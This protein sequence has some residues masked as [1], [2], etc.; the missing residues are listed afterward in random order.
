MRHEKSTGGSESSGGLQG[1]CKT[2][3]RAVQRP[4]E[5]L[6]RASA[7]TSNQQ[8]V[9]KQEVMVEADCELPGLG[10]KD[11]PTSPQALI[12]HWE[13]GSGLLGRPLSVLS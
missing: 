10:L 8:A 12:K 5:G 11:S 7:V 1:V 2:I 3:C 13:T 6:R 9:S 4:G